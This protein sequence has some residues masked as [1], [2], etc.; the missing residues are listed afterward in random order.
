MKMKL[1]KVL[2]FFG[3]D[4][5][6]IKLFEKLVAALNKKLLALQEAFEDFLGPHQ[7]C[8]ECTL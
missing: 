5:L 2:H 1:C 7:N 6:L 8:C 4:V 3:L